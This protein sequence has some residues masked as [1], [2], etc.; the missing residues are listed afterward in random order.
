MKQGAYC[1]RVGTLPDTDYRVQP[2]YM[3]MLDLPDAWQFGRGAGVTVA[4]IDTGVNPHPRLPNLVG[5]GDYVGRRR[6]RPA[7]LR[8]ARHHRGLAHRCRPGRRQDTVAARARDA[9]S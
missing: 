1:P 5:G 6:R 4:V 3:D 2:R 9:A 8:R 7:G